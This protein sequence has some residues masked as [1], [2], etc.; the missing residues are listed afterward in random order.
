MKDTIHTGNG[1]WKIRGPR[2]AS[3][4]TREDPECQ[5]PR[6]LRVGIQNGTALWK[7]I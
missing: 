5:D 6:S 7:M 4:S 3:P 2:P 1:T